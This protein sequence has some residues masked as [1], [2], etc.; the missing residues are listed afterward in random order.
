[1]T[2]R[3]TVTK[4]RQLGRRLG[5]PTANLEVA[6]DL[7]LADGVY[8]ARVEVGGRRYRALANLGTN[9]T[10]GTGGRRLLEIHLMG[11]EGGESLYGREI[12]VEMGCRLRE[13][14]RFATLEELRRQM[15]ADR[16]AVERTFE[17]D[18]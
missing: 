16:A 2:I 9:P 12:T 11:F 13:E 15:E 3:G 18:R 8:A 4:G 5:F 7:P 10:L 14:R 6:D 17:T 1:M